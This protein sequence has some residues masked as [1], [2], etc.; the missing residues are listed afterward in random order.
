MPR[1]KHDSGLLTSAESGEE[2]RGNIDV[3]G[4]KLRQ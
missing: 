4:I 2:I 3:F 1:G